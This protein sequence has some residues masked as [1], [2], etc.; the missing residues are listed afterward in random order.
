MFQG[1]RNALARSEVCA[2]PAIALACGQHR[3]TPT[4]RGPTRDEPHQPRDPT[5]RTGPGDLLH[6]PAQRPHADL[7]A[8]PRGCRHLGRLHQCRH[9]ARRVRHGGPRRIHARPGRWRPDALRPS[10][11]DGDRRGAGQR[12]R[13][14]ECAVQ[15]LAVPPDPG[16]RRAR[17][18]AVPGGNA[19]RGAG[20]RRS[21]PLSA[22]PAGR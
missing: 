4:M 1:S 19:G 2:A 8:G 21:L 22:Q 16:P 13:R 10:H 9:G 15:R 14:G 11:A 6:R 12:H 18:P 3:T 20:L 7:C 5:A 17:H